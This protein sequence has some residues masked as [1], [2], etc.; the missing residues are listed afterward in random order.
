MLELH[1]LPL[2]VVL[3]VPQGPGVP[4]ADQVYPKIIE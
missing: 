4:Q 3:R 2:L 1:P